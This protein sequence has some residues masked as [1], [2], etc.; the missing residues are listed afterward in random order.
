[1]GVGNTG[2]YRLDTYILRPKASEHK[3]AENDFNFLLV[4]IRKFDCF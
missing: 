3:D 4:V 2:V 1:M